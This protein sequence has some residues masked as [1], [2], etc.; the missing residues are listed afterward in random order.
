MGIYFKISMRFLLGKIV[1]RNF[2][3]SVILKQ[4]MNH[5][6]HRRNMNYPKIACYANTRGNA[7]PLVNPDGSMNLVN[8]EALSKFQLITL[9]ITPY[10]DN[11]QDI[12]AKIRELNPSI[13]ILGY[14]IIGDAFLYA[15]P[16]TFWKEMW[17][18]LVSTDGFLY[19]TDGLLY[20]DGYKVNMGKKATMDALQELWIR[21][22]VT[23]NL[24]DG[25][26]LDFCSTDIAW[27]S[28][29]PNRMLDVARAGFT[30]LLAND[31]AR[32]DNLTAFCQNIRAAAPVGFIIVGNGTTPYPL[33][34]SIFDGM[35]FENFPF[36]GGWNSTV[37]N[38]KNQGPY[39]FI[40]SENWN[41]S[42]SSEACRIARFG[43]ASACMGDG[44]ACIG[45]DRDINVFPL[46]FGWNYD[47]YSVNVTPGLFP[48]YPDFTGKHTGWLGAAV[49]PAELMPNGLWKRAFPNGTVFLNPT[50]FPIS[51]D[52]IVQFKYISGKV[53]PFTN[54][55]G[56]DHK[57]TIKANDALFLI[58]VKS[59]P[60][61]HT[62]IRGV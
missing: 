21:K 7:L 8:I 5:C 39:S 45:P 26:F 22:A 14:S 54:H 59:S 10:A 13:K 62:P 43:L 12:V 6:E 52:T 16:N 57:F 15:T 18:I 24:F 32:R 1:C 2:V 56:Y 23:S 48:S 3:G 61:P 30:S 55:S 51:V 31:S 40:K 47:E 4:W 42:V 49:G 35:M 9:N 25:I 60:T 41:P 28:A 33:G 37:A 38:Y 17:D 46:Y 27:T 53:D 44:F 29:A 58:A 50:N 20:T 11:R 36:F 19:G 34:K